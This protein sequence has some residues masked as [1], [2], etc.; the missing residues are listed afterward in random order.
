M[1]SLMYDFEREQRLAAARTE[2]VAACLTVSAERLKAS[3][4]YGI[5]QE[6]M[7]AMDT[8]AK[9][10]VDLLRSPE[11]CPTCGNEVAPGSAHP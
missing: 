6:T 5:A 10:Y 8:A 2:L 1:P 4:A 9:R 3:P 7:D 11:V